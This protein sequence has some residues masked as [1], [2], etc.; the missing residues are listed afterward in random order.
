MGALQRPTVIDTR[1]GN[2]PGLRI[3][4]NCHTGG[5]LDSSYARIL[6]R[7][8]AVLLSNQGAVVRTNQEDALPAP[9][10]DAPD[11]AN[12]PDFDLRM[13]LRA[14]RVHLQHNYLLWGISLA[15]LTLF[16]TTGVKTIAQDIVIRDS[17]GFLLASETLQ[18]RLVRHVGA[19]YW[20]LNTILNW[21]AREDGERLG[22]EA[23][24]KDF[25]RDFYTQISQ[26]VLNSWMRLS[27]HQSP[28]T[29]ERA[30]DKR[31]RDGR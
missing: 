18:A 28:S 21:V 19:G 7:R 20:L 10:D 22:E 4:I 17:T 25:S 29:A 13:D 27:V 24:K 12:Q 8:L 11:E 9:D 31:A 2:F 14:R 26:M 23:T 16:P 6:C 3:Q 1:V 15:T 30:P 5:P